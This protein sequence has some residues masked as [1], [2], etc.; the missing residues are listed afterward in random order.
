MNPKKRRN[1]PQLRM[2]G[3]THDLSCFKAAYE[4]KVKAQEAD[5]MR[6]HDKLTEVHG[7]RD[8]SLAASRRSKVETG[9]YSCTSDR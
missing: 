3:N 2:S 5:S 9:S 4:A 1:I 8:T 7:P 6:R